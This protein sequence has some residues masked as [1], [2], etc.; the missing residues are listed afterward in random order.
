[1]LVA[2]LSANDPFG[3]VE[4]TAEGSVLLLRVR[5]LRLS[6]QGVAREIADVSQGRVGHLRIGVSAAISEQ[7]LSAAFATL[8]E[9]RREQ[10]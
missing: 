5:E 7:F 4:L 3:H 6:L 9:E 1:M 2:S 8:L 10:S